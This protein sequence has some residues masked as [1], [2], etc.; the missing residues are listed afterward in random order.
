MG[1]FKRTGEIAPNQQPA[2]D[3]LDGLRKSLDQAILPERAHEVARKE[4]T[5]LENTDPSLAEYSIGLNYLDFLLALPW[6]R[7]STDNLDLC[8]AE[9]ILNEEHY[10]L[11]RVKER[12][13][14]HLASSIVCSL[15]PFRVLV[16]D[17]EDI[18]RDNI[19]YALRK[20]EVE[21]TTAA[22][23]RE[24]LDIV[25]ATEVDLII[26]DLKMDKVDG[27]ELLH[28]VKEHSPE[29]DIVLVT[30][31]ATVDTAVS[32][33]KQGATHYLPK[34]LNLDVV[35][36][37]VQDAKAKRQHVRMAHGPIL[38]FTGPPGTGKTSIGRAVAKALERSFIRLSMAGLRDE[39]ELRG[40]RRTYV[41]SM[42]G[43]IISELRKAGVNNP[44][45]MLDE[46]DK[47]GQDFRGDPASVLLEVLDPE[48]NANFLDY[49]LDIPFDLSK[50]MFITTANIPEN[51]PGPLLDMTLERS[52]GMSR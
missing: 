31:Y 9:R 27:M 50:V 19:A 21:V 2:P 30:G 13:L 5:R 40:H 36:R 47:I 32:A 35:R 3:A 23:G 20:A 17:D 28:R 43:R 42:P 37:T 49:Y 39:A 52:K 45:F 38:C 14:E 46:I 15:K 33:L 26:T 34:P 4:L 25:A 44:V 11:G 16:V 8:R 41:G 7:S 1:F 29:T 10:G 6:S 22:N 48:Q 51:L 18:A 12:V 24:A